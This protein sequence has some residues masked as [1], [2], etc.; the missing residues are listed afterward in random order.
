MQHSTI[1]PASE[2]V[3]PVMED[4]AF[5]D[6]S[7]NSDNSDNASADENENEID[8]SDSNSNKSD[9]GD[10]VIPTANEI[11]MDILKQQ[12]K[13]AN[14]VLKHIGQQLRCLQFKGVLSFQAFVRTDSSLER[15]PLVYYEAIVPILHERLR[16]RGF[17]LESKLKK[18]SDERLGHETDDILFDYSIAFD[19]AEQSTQTSAQTAEPVENKE[20]LK[21]SQGRELVTSC[22]GELDVLPPLT[23]TLQLFPRFDRNG[24]FRS[25]GRSYVDESSPE[26]ANCAIM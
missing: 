7:D 16:E 13:L 21:F 10:D 2:F 25:Y 14:L 8:L 6:T 23:P 5:S 22:E 26:F 12:S 3:L 11:K 20:D 18:D 4:I 24:V 1:I 17:M 15:L 9:M 19:T